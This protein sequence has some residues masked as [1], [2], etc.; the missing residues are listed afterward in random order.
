MRLAGLR[1]HHRLVVPFVLVA[2]AATS[3]AAYVTLAV[4]RRAFEQRVQRQLQS[5]AEVVARPEFATNRVVLRSV[6]RITGAEVLTFTTSGR[7]LAGTVDPGA[8]PEL[9]RHVVSAWAP[10]GAGVVRRFDCGTPCL[11]T[12]QPVAGDA[13]RIVALVVDTSELSTATQSVTRAVLVTAGLSIVAMIVASQ[14]VARRVTAPLARLSDFV[15][16]RGMRGGRDRASVGSDEIGQLGAAFNDMLDRVEASQAAVVQS[17]KLALAGLLA[18]RVAHDI[19]NPLSSVKVQVQLLQAGDHG[20]DLRAPFEEILHDVGVIEAVVSNLLEL[21]RPGSLQCREV[22]LNA[23]VDEALRQV[24]AQLSHRR[25]VVDT[26]FAPALPTVSLDSTRI[27]QALINLIA[28]ASEAMPTGGT[29]TVA[30]R[31]AGEGVEIEL[32]DDGIGI[33][34]A[35]LETVFNPF[36]TTKRDGVGLGL[37]N[38]RAVVESHGGQVTL[39]PRAPCGTR[40][41]IWLPLQPPVSAERHG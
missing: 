4:A 8:H 19:R 7:L 29:L 33:D 10:G 21:A 30:T 36:V 35:L 2:L 34:P 18:A 3:T 9:I 13:T 27:K 40:A 14:M 6:R 25:I 39:A 20:S 15:R 24:R 12:F 26:R 17:E 11:V 16:H 32:C 23:V 28:N 41:R 1:L 37:V 38:T 22:A 5:A 31:V